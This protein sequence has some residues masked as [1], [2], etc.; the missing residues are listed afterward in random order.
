[1]EKQKLNL[2][3]AQLLASRAA[4]M[5]AVLTPSEERLWQAICSRQLGIAFRRQVVLGRYI[6][7]FCAPAVRLVVEVDG[8]YHSRRGRADMRRDRWLAEAGY[9]VLRLE[10]GLVMRELP[11]ALARVQQALRAANGA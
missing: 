11:L 2:A 4:A 8:P 1:L 3:R 10:A 5:R 9:R 6:V 7:D